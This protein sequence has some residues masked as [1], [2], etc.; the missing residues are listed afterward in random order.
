MID[1]NVPVSEKVDRKR[2]T[3]LGKPGKEFF[4]K[5]STVRWRIRDQDGKFREALR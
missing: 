4:V 3:A 1:P 5:S 2:L